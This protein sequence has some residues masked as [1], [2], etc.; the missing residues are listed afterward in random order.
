MSPTK[1][2]EVF[3]D[4]DCPLCRREIGVL[5]SLDRKSKIQFTDI[6]AP[7]FDDSVLSGISV[8]RADLMH[9]I[10]GRDSQTG[11]WVEGVEVFRRL[12]EAVGFRRLVALS[13]LAPIAWVLDR[14][15]DWFAANRLWI[16]GRKDSCETG[17]CAPK[18]SR[19]P[20]SRSPAKV[21]RLN[22]RLFN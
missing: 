1:S 18:S 13:R 16:T 7:D 10:H 3:F 21:T 22:E 5:R 4:G 9:R 6:A 2:F 19:G 12:Y 17:V 14:A 20:I 11:T 15:Y 8:S